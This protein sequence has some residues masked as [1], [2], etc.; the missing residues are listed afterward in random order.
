MFISV[1]SYIKQTTLKNYGLLGCQ[2]KIKGKY[3]QRPGDRRKVYFYR[4]GSFSYSNPVNKYIISHRQLRDK[5]GA[6]G[7]TVISMLL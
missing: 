6:S 4:I 5:S 2:I 3:T 7:C 1:F